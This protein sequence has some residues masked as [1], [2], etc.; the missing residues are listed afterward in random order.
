MQSPRS[1]RTL[2]PTK[3]S[4]ASHFALSHWM[5]VLFTALTGA[6]WADPGSVI[7][8]AKLSGNTLT[9]EVRDF[10][11]GEIT[12]KFNDSIIPATY[13]EPVQRITATFANVPAPG[14][15]LLAVFKRDNGNILDRADVTIGAVGPQGPPGVAGPVGATGPQGPAGPTGAKGDTG[16][17]GPA[18]P[19]GPTGPQGPQG[20]PGSGGGEPLSGSMM[21]SGSALVAGYTYTGMNF[22]RGDSWVSKAP[23][24][25]SRVAPAVAAAGGKIYAIGGYAFGGGS[26]SGDEVEEYDPV[27]DSWVSRASMPSVRDGCAAAAWG[28]KVYLIG[29]RNEDG[30]LATV[31]VYDPASDTWAAKTPMPTARQRLAVV[32]LG[33]KIYAV[34]GYN[35]DDGDLATVEEYD[36]VGD[37]W[38]SKAPMP[39]ARFEH[40]VAALGGKVYAIGGY[41]D[42]I[43]YVAAL[44]EY[45]P[46]ANIWVSK[47]SMPTA[48][49]RLAAATSGGKIY[50]IGGGQLDFYE[51]AIISKAVEE[52]D[53]V[54]NTWAPKALMPAARAEFGAAEVNGR[55][56]AIGGYDI[57]LNI[58]NTIEQ[59]TPGQTVFILFKN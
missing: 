31:E 48:R 25:T 34:G 41:S 38:A 30:D 26:G 33:D 57:S 15:Y 6:A 29:G 20:P 40:A 7:K 45:D 43:N 5:V 44:E 1:N 23:I 56:Y 35:S 51:Y 8:S 47:A 36:P 58:V 19:Q 27:A 14:T 10:P 37:T 16:D 13:D 2:R 46:V 54:A 42:T 53:P 3:N 11:K 59:F 12:V 21:V 55:L 18:G 9:I 32:T 49:H 28:G 17:T 50:A 22:S 24:P 4:R 52:Y 39:T